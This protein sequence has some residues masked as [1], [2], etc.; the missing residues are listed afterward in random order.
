MTIPTF[1]VKECIDLLVPSVT[2]LVNMCI[3]EGHFPQDF[4][5]SVVTPLIKKNILAK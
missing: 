4:N 2:E 5:K 1:F 3:V